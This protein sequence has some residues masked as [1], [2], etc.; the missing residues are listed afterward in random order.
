MMRSVLE[1]IRSVFWRRPRLGPDAA[2]PLLRQV[3]RTLDREYTCDEVAAVLGEVAEAV[4]RGQDLG[5]LMPLVQHHLQMCGDCRE[6]L[7]AL[8]RV[9]RAGR[10]DG[11]GS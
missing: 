3:E 5:A 8:L 10:A 6:E 2:A 11:G 9:L 1:S 7:E 4:Q